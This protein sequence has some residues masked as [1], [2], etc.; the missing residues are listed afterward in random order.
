[1]GSCAKMKCTYRLLFVLGG[2]LCLL[3]MLGFN[4]DVT[5]ILRSEVKPVCDDLVSAL[6]KTTSNPE[7]TN[8]KSRETTVSSRL[9]E[10]TGGEAITPGLAP[11]LGSQAQVHHSLENRIPNSHY[12]SRSRSSLDK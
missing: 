9:S 8:A 1:M 2:L 7:M 6:S 3:L 11:T 10:M 12:E 4:G 5:R